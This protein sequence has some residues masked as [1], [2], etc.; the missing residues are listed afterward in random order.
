MTSTTRVSPVCVGA[1][2]GQESQ[3]SKSANIENDLADQFTSGLD[4]ETGV[5]DLLRIPT[6]WLA[7]DIGHYKKEG[8]AHVSR[9]I[10]T[11]LGRMQSPQSRL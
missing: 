8:F 4:V 5:P 7:D 10:M 3:Y 6:S 1:C 11:W 2:W 9:C